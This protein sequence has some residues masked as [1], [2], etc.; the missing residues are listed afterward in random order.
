MN[1]EKSD[2]ALLT[3]PHPAPSRRP[4]ARL[5]RPHQFCVRARPNC[6]RATSTMGD[7]RTSQRPAGRLQ[8]K[9]SGG[10]DDVVS[11]L[12]RTPRTGSSLR[13]KLLPATFITTPNSICLSS[14]PMCERRSESTSLRTRPARPRTIIRPGQLDAATSRLER[15][16]VDR[17]QMSDRSRMGSLARS[18]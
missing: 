12:A 17:R 15:R 1:N 5:R 4:R 8:I 13:F 6:Q 10:T 7:A 14:E 9:K 18:R 3:G 2:R 16:E 11:T